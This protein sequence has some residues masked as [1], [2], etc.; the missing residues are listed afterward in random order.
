MTPLKRRIKS[1]KIKYG[2]AQGY[3]YD[4]GK[5][6]FGDSEENRNVSNRTKTKKL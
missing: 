3:S 4:L 1:V 5:I 2:L 6:A